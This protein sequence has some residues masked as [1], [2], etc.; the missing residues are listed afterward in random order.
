MDT[1]R[2]AV[3]LLLASAC[4][5]LPVVIGAGRRTLLQEDSLP[6]IAPRYLAALNNNDSSFTFGYNNFANPPNPSIF[7]PSSSFLV[8]LDGLCVRYS[9]AGN[10]QTVLL[11]FDGAAFFR[12]FAIV[13]FYVRSVKLAL[14]TKKIE[15]SALLSAPGLDHGFAA[16]CHLV[17]QLHHHPDVGRNVCPMK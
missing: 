8:R 3:L 5:A 16:L 12:H 6:T 1:K 15:L 2:A 4:A 13:C 14:V 17:K 11:L 7:L 9:R 10:I